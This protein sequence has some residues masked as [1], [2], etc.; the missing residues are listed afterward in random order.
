[1]SNLYLTIGLPGSGKSTWS[2]KKAQDEENTIIVNRDS[3]RT[4]IKNHYV[5]NNLYE[6]YIKYVTDEAILSGLDHGFDV[7]VDETH[8]KKIRRYEV[9]YL[10]EHR[11]KSTN[12]IYVWFLENKRNIEFRMKD[13]RGYDR[14]EWEK[15]INNMKSIFEEPTEDEKYDQIIKI[16]PLDDL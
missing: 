13:S 2:K 7:I 11:R 12:V 4:M 5:Y 10:L 8:V 15:V 16:N 6:N 9:L 1:M 3:L 14:N